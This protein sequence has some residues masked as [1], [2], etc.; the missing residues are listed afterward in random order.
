MVEGP[1]IPK[2]LVILL[3]YRRGFRQEGMAC[4]PNNECKVAGNFTFLLE[5]KVQ[6]AA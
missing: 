2:L 3:G 4:K 6:D 5:L 1:S